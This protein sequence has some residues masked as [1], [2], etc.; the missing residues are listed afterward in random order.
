MDISK[1][2]NSNVYLDGT[3]KLLGKA[4]EF[5][6]P[7]IAAVTEEHKALGMIGKLELVMGLEKLE[8]K[9]KWTGFYPEHLDGANPFAARKLQV[10]SNVQTFGPSGLLTELPLVTSLTA[11]FK[12]IPLGVLGAGAGVELEDELSVSYIK[13]DL[14]G[15]ELL[16]IDIHENIWRV[17]GK[18]ILAAYRA[19]IGA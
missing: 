9:V 4:G 13:Q 3:N 16:E 6:L 19:N 11:T 7:D 15:Q 12:K 17:R 5:T 18:D 10:R 1:I 14:A 2:Y 8:A